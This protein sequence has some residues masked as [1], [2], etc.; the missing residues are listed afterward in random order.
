MKTRK[1][2]LNLSSVSEINDT[3]T[4]ILKQG[5]QKML[6][7]AVEAEVD[8]FICNHS[9]IRDNHDRRLIVR[10]GYSPER[11]L[12]TG[13]GALT[14]KAPRVRDNSGQLIKFTSTLLPP[15]L[16]RTKSI[17]DLLPWLYLKGISTGDFPEALT[18]LLGDNAKGLSANTIS[19]LKQVWQDEYDDWRKK[20]LSALNIVYMW[21]D[22]V[23]PKVRL[24]EEKQCVLVV[25]GADD[26]GKKHVLALNDGYRESEQSWAEILLDLK[27][28][29]LKHVPKLAVGDGA[30][31]F[32]NALSKIFPTTKHQRC[33]V[34]KTRNILNKLPKSL[35]AKAK[36]DIHDI[37]MADT[38]KDAVKAFNLFI[39]KY[40]AKY[41]KATKCLNKDR[42]CLLTFYDFPAEH[43]HHIR[44]SNPIESLFA[45]IKLRTAKT[46]GCLSRTTGLT[47]MYKLAMCAENRWPK[48]RGSK[49]VL[50]V[51][52]GIKFNNGIEVKEYA[53]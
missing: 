7:A 26:T 12:Q 49:L 2:E 24:A 37:W 35:H 25:I 51:F 50:K 36:S 31:G 1:D 21:V 10:N 13:L 17:E 15:Y 43:W 18:A 6:M 3:L 8:S 20:D 32:W 5:A 23:Y 39:T 4:A 29:G 53:A 28:R 44:T 46:R 22:G 52:N 16:K 14:V 41:P 33:W 48:L 11:D 42:D 30:L 34:H 9:H 38:R 45:T 47:M 40:E 19:R 27:N